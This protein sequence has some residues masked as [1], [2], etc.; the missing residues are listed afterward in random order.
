MPEIP[1]SITLIIPLVALAA[2]PLIAALRAKRRRKAEPTPE[3]PASRR[4]AWS[5]FAQARARHPWSGS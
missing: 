1:D 3:M 5:G 2:A 4:D